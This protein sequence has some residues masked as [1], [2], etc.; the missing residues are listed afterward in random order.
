MGL[1]FAGLGTKVI[2][3]MGDARLSL[4][5]LERWNPARSK[6]HCLSPRTKFLV[7]AYHVIV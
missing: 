4:P 7:Q 5:L 1:L 6:V 3:L 2:E